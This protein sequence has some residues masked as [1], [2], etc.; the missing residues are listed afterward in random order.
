M[1]YFTVSEMI[2]MNGAGGNVD[3]VDDSAHD[4]ITRYNGFT[5]CLIEND[6]I[7]IDA[8]FDYDNAYTISELLSTTTLQSITITYPTT[9]SATQFVSSGFISNYES[10]DPFDDLIQISVT[11]KISGKP[12][13]SKV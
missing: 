4:S 5:K 2:S 9:P 6:E 1:I 8:Y 11:I 13:I 12:S 3:M 7:N 10:S